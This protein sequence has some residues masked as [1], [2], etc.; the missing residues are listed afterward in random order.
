VGCRHLCFDGRGGHGR[1]AARPL[2]HRPGPRPALPPGQ[3]HREQPEDH[4]H[5]TD[6]D[7]V[8]IGVVVTHE[9]ANS[10]AVAFAVAVALPERLAFGVADTERVAVADLPQPVSVSVTVADEV[11]LAFGEPL[12]AG[13]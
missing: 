8:T 5:L 13:G 3:Q 6:A 9:V 12:A 11:A 1:G 2:L 7:R 4:L 10:I